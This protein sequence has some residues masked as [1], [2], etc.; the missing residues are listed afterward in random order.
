MFAIEAMRSVFVAALPPSV[1]SDESLI[2]QSDAHHK[3]ARASQAA[4]HARDRGVPGAEP[5]H[6]SHLEARDGPGRRRT[7]GSPLVALPGCPLSSRVTSLSVSSEGTF[8][9]A[10]CADGT[11]AAWA[12]ATPQRSGTGTHPLALR[13]RASSGSVIRLLAKDVPVA[14]GALGRG[15]VA[16]QC[17]MPV[18]GAAQSERNQGAATRSP[19]IVSVA[20]CGATEGECDEWGGRRL[21]GGGPGV[22]RGMAVIGCDDG[23][24]S[25]WVLSA[26][27]VEAGDEDE[28][29]GMRGASSAT[30]GAGGGIAEQ[31]GAYCLGAL[32]CSA[33]SGPMTIA[34][35]AWGDLNAVQC[36]FGRDTPPGED[37]IGRAAM[38]LGDSQG[39]VQL[40]AL[41]AKGGWRMPHDPIGAGGSSVVPWVKLGV[42]RLL[43]SGAVGAGGT[44]PAAGLDAAARMTSATGVTSGVG[45]TRVALRRWRGAGREGIVEMPS[46]RA[47]DFASESQVAAA[48]SNGWLLL[49]GGADGAVRRFLASDSAREGRSMAVARQRGTRV[50]EMRGAGGSTDVRK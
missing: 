23:T 36:T 37:L 32:P 22:Q 27:P 4:R 17:G 2:T 21:L 8:V 34:L 18:G 12:L 44:V 48:S 13:R 47:P 9:V 20:V 6:S 33:P 29:R 25:A 1:T 31:A 5:M 26:G 42:C 46:M 19:S 35:C 16:A 3:V 49:A 7:P 15:V 40:W 30:D 11:F 39:R 24:F 41:S 38:A 43:G 50:G 28:E 10:G 45:V 14:R